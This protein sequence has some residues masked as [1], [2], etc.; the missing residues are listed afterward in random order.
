[1]PRLYTADAVYSDEATDLSGGWTLPTN[2]WPSATPPDGLVAEG[3][4][5]GEVVPDVR[6]RDQFG[7]EVSLWQFSGQVTLLDV[8]TIW[9]RPCQVLAQ[10]TEHTWQDYRD[11]GFIY[12]T[13]LHEDASGAE[14]DTDDLRLW[15]DQ[16][17]QA[18]A[19]PITSPVVADPRGSL[20]TASMIL[21]GQYPAVVVIGRDL[22]VRE[23]VDQ[24]SDGPVRDA[25]ER[26]LAE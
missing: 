15:A 10:D 7:E 2:R 20:G 22:V 8:S 6:A 9:C 18:P 26:A 16:V 12:L 11:E 5:A 4:H 19:L 25:I 17:P 14:P 23:R 21:N 13:V 24:P 3:F 1:M